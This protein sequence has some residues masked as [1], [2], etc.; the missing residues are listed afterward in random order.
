VVP[1]LSGLTI[2]AAGPAGILLRW[3]TNAVD[4][5]LES[6][7]TMNGKRWY[8]VPVTPI[9]TNGEY[10]VY[11]PMTGPSQFFRLSDGPPTLEL[12]AVAGKLHLA[13]PTAPS[14]FQLESCDPMQPANWT[15]VL[16]TPA[17]SNAFN[18]VDV[19]LQLNTR[20]KLFR[21]KK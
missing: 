16:I 9:N 17:A 8:P 14:G 19:P 15:P 21:L 3:P 7:P 13:W 11:Q 20:G 1:A 5:R 10:R 6:S 4:Y 18:H 12:S 2:S